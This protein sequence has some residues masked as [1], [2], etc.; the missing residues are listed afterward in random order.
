MSSNPRVT[1]RVHGG[2]AFVSET[3]MPQT[4]AGVYELVAVCP[5]CDGTKKV[6]TLTSKHYA[7]SLISGSERPCPVCSEEARIERARVELNKCGAWLSDDS[8]KRVVAAYK[9]DEG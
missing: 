3:L 6:P 5:T 8:I 7:D 9:G 1:V 2:E 4:P